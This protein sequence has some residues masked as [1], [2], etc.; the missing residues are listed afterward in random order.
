MSECVAESAVSDKAILA[1]E[2]RTAITAV[3]AGSTGL[4]VGLVIG[5]D[6]IALPTSLTL[7]FL[8]AVLSAEMFLNAGEV[9]ESAGRVMVDAAG[10]GANVHSFSSRWPARRMLPELPR[11]VMPAPVE[12]K[13]LLAL[14][15]S[16]ADLADEAV[17]RH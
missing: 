15:P 8:L 3:L 14:E 7:P 16:V 9:A 12:L 6:G 10:L 13:V 5:P 2:E 4:G 17:W 11:E 1:R